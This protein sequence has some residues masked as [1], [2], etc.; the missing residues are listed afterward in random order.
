MLKTNF[1]RE[2]AAEDWILL[3]ALTVLGYSMLK[4][5]VLLLRFFFRGFSEDIYFIKSRSD[6][7]GLPLL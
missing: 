3:G 2:D 5:V 1:M 7:L 4:L 6:S